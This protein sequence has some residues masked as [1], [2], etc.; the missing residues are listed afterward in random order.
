MLFGSKTEKFIK[1]DFA[2]GFYL[3][4]LKLEKLR[5]A[6]II[7]TKCGIRSIKSVDYNDSL[8]YYLENGK[9]ILFDTNRLKDELIRNIITHDRGLL[10]LSIY[11]LTTILHEGVHTYQD[12]ILFNREY[13]LFYDFL[14]DSLYSNVD[15]KIYREKPYFFPS[16][17]QAEIEVW[18]FIIPLLLRKY[19]EYSDG[20]LDL[21]I[22]NISMLVR[23]YYEEDTIFSPLDTFYLEAYGRIVSS[24]IDLTKYTLNDRFILGLPIDKN[25]IFKVLEDLFLLNN[26]QCKKLILD[27]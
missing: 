15:D 19:K 26:K 10:Y 8:G 20:I 27:M 21:V 17:R 11:V 9:S 5:R 4:K 25:E 7:D 16:E 6:I 13:S 18:S 14:K 23:P 24:K 22:D 12:K 2:P 1:D 3:H